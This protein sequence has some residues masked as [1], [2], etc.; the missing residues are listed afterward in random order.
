ML[1]LFVTSGTKYIVLFSSLALAGAISLVLGVAFVWDHFFI[2]IRNWY[3]SK[4][5]AVK[6]KNN[7]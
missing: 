3:H 4:K 6:S 5:L 1:T 2:F 7:S